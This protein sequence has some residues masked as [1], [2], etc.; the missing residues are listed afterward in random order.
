MF[1]PSGVT[2]DRGNCFYRRLPAI[3]V[4][5]EPRVR[6]GDICVLLH[7]TSLRELG[8][9]DAPNADAVLGPGADGLTRCFGGQKVPPTE[10]AILCPG[11]SVISPDRLLAI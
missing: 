2:G 10:G 3:V 11:I 6:R 5:H 7:P 1:L 8:P 4:G 9:A